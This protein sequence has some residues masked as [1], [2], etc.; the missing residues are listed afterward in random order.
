MMIALFSFA[1]RIFYAQLPHQR[2][3]RYTLI[4][5]IIIIQTDIFRDLYHDG[6]SDLCS[7]EELISVTR[8]GLNNDNS[9][10]VSSPTRERET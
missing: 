1:R 4:I 3:T 8:P 6:L 2:Y 9:A 5:I 10:D 7:S